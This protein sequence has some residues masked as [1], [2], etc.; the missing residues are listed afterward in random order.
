MF[1][2]VFIMMMLIGGFANAHQF[3]PTYPKFE[4]S[5][6]EGVY[7]TKMELFNK[8]KEIDFFELGVP[9]LSD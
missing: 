5:F 2:Y 7:F 6:V 1:R 3:T 8:R 4:T 9:F